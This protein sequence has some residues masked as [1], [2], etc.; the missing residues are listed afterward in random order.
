LPDAGRI[1][2]KLTMVAPPEIDGLPPAELKQ[3]LLKLLEQN[4]EQTR[5]IAELREE[6]ART[7]T[8]GTPNSFEMGT[9]ISKKIVKSN[10]S[11]VQP[12]QAAT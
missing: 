7:L 5:V 6:I 10:A 8:N 4:A 2:S 11:S 3:L 12:S 9:M 1:D